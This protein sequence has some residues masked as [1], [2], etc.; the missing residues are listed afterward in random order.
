VPLVPIAAFLAGSL[1]SLLLPTL[2]LIALVVWYV[3]FIG[4]VPGPAD[5]SEPA[6]P[7]SGPNPDPGPNTGQNPANITTDAPAPDERAAGQ[8]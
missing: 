3:R 6:R 4:R 5:V 2:L 7:A 1:L 8:P